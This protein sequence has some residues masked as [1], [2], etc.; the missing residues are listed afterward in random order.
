MQKIL[1]LIALCFMMVACS[2]GQQKDAKS[3]ETALETATG[4][5]Y[6][7]VK[8]NTEQGKFVV[9]K[10]E[11]TGE[12]LS[13]N[14]DKWDR[15]TMTTLDQFQAVAVDG[16]DI[17]RNLKKDQEWVSSG[18][19]EA[20]Y[21][22]EYD[23]YDV[24]DSYCS[25]YK[26]EYRTVQV[27]VGDRYVDTSHWYTFY[28][29]GGL[30]FDNTSGASKDLET[31]AALEEAAA[32]KFMS[33]KLKSEFSLSDSRASE[34]AKLASR[35]QK[36]EN[37]RELTDSEKDT[38]ALSGLGVSMK[39]VESALK[40]KA[41]GNDSAYNDLLKTAAQVNKTTPEQIGKFF[42]EMVAENL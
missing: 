16:R 12:F 5:K 8:L 3:F 23:Y 24:Y 42:N 27:Y 38:F 9:Y 35:Y 25:C 31:F 1:A 15:N 30:R 10:N 40:N 18:Y 41:Q 11:Q 22:T 32:E 39:Q 26:S 37:T 2:S 19:W 33:Y 29:G 7:I 17:V 14:M 13:V 34:L 20:I 28:V 6:K 21:R 36:L 4:E